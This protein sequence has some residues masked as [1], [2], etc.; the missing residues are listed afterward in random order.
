MNAMKERDLHNE[1]VMSTHD[2]HFAVLDFALVRDDLAVFL[3]LGLH[4]L[5]AITL[6][7]ALYY[8]I[9]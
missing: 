1:S 4:H 7:G 3:P 5:V 2:F 8:S 6:V 9:R